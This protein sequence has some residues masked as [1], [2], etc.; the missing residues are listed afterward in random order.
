MQLQN[1]CSFLYIFSFL[2]VPEFR[3]LQS[4]HAGYWDSGN[5]ESISS[6]EFMFLSLNII[7]AGFEAFGLLKLSHVNLAGFIFFFQYEGPAMRCLILFNHECLSFNNFILILYVSLHSH[8]LRNVI[9][10]IA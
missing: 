5:P 6:G 10:V 3:T 9:L 4:L 1:M 2:S 8:T 7:I